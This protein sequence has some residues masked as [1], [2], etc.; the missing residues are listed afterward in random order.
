MANK[1]LE[2]RDGAVSLK[3]YLADDG[4]SGARPGVVLFPEAFGIGEHVM[5]RAR[6]LSAVGYVALA[7]DPYGEGAQAK[8]LPGAIQMMTDVRSDVNRWRARAQAALDALSAQ[9]GVDRARL[10]AIGYCFGGST[11][12]E[13]GRSGAPLAAIVSFHGG[14]EAPRPEDARN[15]RARV[16]VC[17]GAND[18]LIPPEQVAA[19]EAQMRATQA[20][21][22]LVS[23]GGAVHS[24][25]NPDADTLGNPALAY[26][27][28]A[29]RRSWAAMLALFQE[30]F[31]AR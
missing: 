27:A 20:D 15:I 21:W 13:L 25:T 23:Y 7:A 29:D 17:H 18:P 8:D 3:G 22:Q 28:A 2:Y 16:L 11:A 9:P 1:T 30:A 26:N 6:R 12:L 14:L 19:F 24:F 10:A 31:A 4:R 5:E